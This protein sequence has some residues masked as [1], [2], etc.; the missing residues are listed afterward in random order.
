M[1]VTASFSQYFENAVLSWFRGTTFPAVPANVYLALFTTPPVNGI[2]AGSVEVPSSN[3][4]ARVAIVPN[5]T[6]FGAPSGAAPASIASGVNFVFPTPT[7]AGW[8]T[9]SGWALFDAASNGNMLAY[10]TFTPTLVS[11]GDTVEFLSG[12]LTLTAT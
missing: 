2:T 6:N 12:N 9:V 10:G 11:A 8:G 4:Y 7:G 1:T 5:T 3:A